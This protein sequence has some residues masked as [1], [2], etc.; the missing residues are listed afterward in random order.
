MIT[1][2]QPVAPAYF[3]Y[4]AMLNRQDRELLDEVTPPPMLDHAA[5]GAA[6]A[7][8]AIL[9]DTRSPE[10]FAK[11][12]LPGSI[13]VGLAGRYAEFAGSVIPTDADIVIVADTDQ[14]IEARNRLARV[15]FD[16]VVGAVADPTPWMT[17]TAERLTADEYAADERDVQLVDVR[18]PGEV[19]D[20]VIDG[21]ITIPV[22]QLPAR[23]DELDPD[24]RTVVYCAGGYRSSVAASLLRRAGFAEVADIDGG[25]SAWTA[26]EPAAV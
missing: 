14:V 16:R 12:H 15:G 5:A 21:A 19:A 7:S 20:G 13:N 24:R 25:W 1:T 3:G 17:A 6:V 26:R 9:L 10:A 2:G 18:N 8:G 4:N 22:M 23:L 11:G